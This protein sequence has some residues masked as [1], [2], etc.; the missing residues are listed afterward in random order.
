MADAGAAIS[1]VAKATKFDQNDEMGMAT[2]ASI[3]QGTGV[4]VGSDGKLVHASQ[5]GALYTLGIAQETKLSVAAGTTIKTRQGIFRLANDAGHLLTIA[6]RL[7]PCY[8]TD[9]QTV[10]S[11]SSK[12][13]AGVVYDVDAGGVWVIMGP[14]LVS[15]ASVGALLAASNLSDVASAPAAAHSLGLGT[16]DSPTFTA[17]TLTGGLLTAVTATLTGLLT[18]VTG[19]FT[20]IVSHLYKFAVK[21]TTFAPA[22]GVDSG[23]TFQS[24]TDGQVFTLPACAAGNLGQRMTF[25]NTGADGAALIKVNPTGTNKIKG[26]V[27]TVESAGASSK[28][29]WNTK[30]TAKQGDHVTVQSDG[31][32]VWWIVGGIGVWASE[33]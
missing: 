15:A 30:A 22:N 33:T 17:V 20:G 28:G 11:D 9:D 16:A 29:W 12:L 21:T 3:Y 7:G 13:L 8:W 24:L 19:A 4:A 14:C 31:A 6:H 23:A 18:G 10:G 2:S 27:G 1:T 26:Q 32:D 5:A 25:Q